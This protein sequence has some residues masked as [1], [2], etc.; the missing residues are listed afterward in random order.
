MTKSPGPA[1]RADAPNAA[2]HQIEELHKLTPRDLRERYR[3][4]FGVE[5]SSPCKQQLV[6]RISWKLQALAHGDL[7]ER[8]RCRIVEIS[9]DPE[10]RIQLPA[11]LVPIRRQGSAARIPRRRTMEYSALKEGVELQR[12]FRGRTVVVKVLASGFEYEGQ[13]Y[14]SLSAVARAATG[15][16][17]NGLVFF[18]VKKQGEATQERTRA[19]S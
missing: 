1:V 4:L 6:R 3:E 13:S 9:Q 19:A 18:G 10:P 7:S 2:D 12:Q 5:L 15:T 8:A 14:G 16:R 17:W 11:V